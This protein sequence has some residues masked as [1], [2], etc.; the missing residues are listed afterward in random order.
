MSGRRRIFL[1]IGVV[2]VALVIHTGFIATPTGPRD[3]RAFDPEIGR[4]LTDSYRSLR[5]GVN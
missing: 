3:V 4:L 1:I 5:K 2:L